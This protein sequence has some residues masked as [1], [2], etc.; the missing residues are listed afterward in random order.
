[1][2]KNAGCKYSKHQIIREGFLAFLNTNEDVFRITANEVINGLV[3]NGFSVVMP[4]HLF[5]KKAV[6][7]LNFNKS[8]FQKEE[9]ELV[10]EITCCNQWLKVAKVSKF[11]NGYHIKIE[12]NEVRMANQCFENAILMY[13]FSY[14]P[15]MISTQRQKTSESNMT[16]F[17]FRCYASNDHLTAN[18]TKPREYKF[19]LNVHKL[20]IIGE[21]AHRPLRWALPATGIIGQ[22]HISFTV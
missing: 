9:N 12:C 10:L 6:N 16:K 19:A 13:S 1:M 14:P 5:S 20:I 2:L 11:T 4:Q 18:C 7:K 17:C 15:R 22:C 21:T 3:N 8:F